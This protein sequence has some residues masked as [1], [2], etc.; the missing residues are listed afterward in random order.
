MA[1]GVTDADRVWRDNANV[2][3]RAL[4][5]VGCKASQNVYSAAGLASREK[6]SV[7]TV[8]ARI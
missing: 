8:V 2:T 7:G 6:C 4:P 3:I 1:E 5:S